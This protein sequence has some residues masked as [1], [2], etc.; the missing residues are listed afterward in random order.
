MSDDIMRAKELLYSEDCTLVILNGDKTHIS[1]GRGIGPL[2]EIIDSGEDLRGASAADRIVGKAAAMLYVMSGVG[3]IYA[4]VLSRSAVS[5]FERYGTAYSFKTLTEKIMNRSG[6]GLCPMEQ[7]V[8][9]ID[10]PEDAL[11]ALREKVRELKN[12]R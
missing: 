5:V 2:L 7:T 8:L 10:D 1:R 3:S 11:T 4:E 9:D 6:T 12:G